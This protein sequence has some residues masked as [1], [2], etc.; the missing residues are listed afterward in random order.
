MIQQK[1]TTYRNSKRVKMSHQ[2]CFEGEK[3]AM[4]H[5]EKLLSVLGVQMLTP[6]PA[7]GSKSPFEKIMLLALFRSEIQKGDI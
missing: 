2:C 6:P 4:C 7:H 5:L 1:T 3:G